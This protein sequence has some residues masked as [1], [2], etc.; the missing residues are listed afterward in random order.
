MSINLLVAAV[1]GGTG[2]STIATSLAGYLAGEGVDTML[3]DTDRTLT[4]S[5][6]IA[7][8]NRAGGL[9][10]IHGAQ[11]R[12]DVYETVKDLVARYQ[13]LIID[14]PGND[15]EELT[16]AILACDIVVVPLRASGPDLAVMPAMQALVRKTR[17]YNPGLKAYILISI[18]PTNTHVKEAQLARQ[19]LADFTEFE[20]LTSQ[21]H[22]RKVYRDAL[23]CGR[24]ATEMDNP[25]ARAEVQLLAQELFGLPQNS[26]STS[27]LSSAAPTNSTVTQEINHD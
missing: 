9:P 8:R 3:L 19:Y 11:Q 20:V 22:D 26:C 4:S 25:T 10:K 14:S 1:K 27:V 7:Q 16:S 12:A 24:S 5:H 15:C 17:R 21:V 13:A 6:W 18:A 2:K 23:L